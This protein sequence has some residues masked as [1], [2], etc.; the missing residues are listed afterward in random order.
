VTV[1]YY[2]QDMTEDQVFH[3]FRQEIAPLSRQQQWPPLR[4]TGLFAGVDPVSI[5]KLTTEIMFGR[6][7]VSKHVILHVL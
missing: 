7:L 5:I 1:L 2:I 4:A 3:R 6:L